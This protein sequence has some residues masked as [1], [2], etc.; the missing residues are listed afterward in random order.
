TPE[1]GTEIRIRENR[2]APWKTW[3]KVGPEE[4]VGVDGFS[5][6]SKAAYVET[7]VGSDTVRLVQKDLGSGAEK[8]IA[9]SDEVDAGAVMIN[10]SPRV[11][12]AV[13]FEPGRREWQATDPAVKAHFDGIPKLDAGDFAIASRD[14][15][16]KHWLVVFTSD[17]GPVKYYVWDR[18]AKS[19]TYL[20]S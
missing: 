20:F 6:D 14:H 19:G 4:N 16:D 11:L 17:R 10:A 15:A 5:A 3:I 13:P 1:G 18:A 9:Y 7:S 8:V 2:S 12:E